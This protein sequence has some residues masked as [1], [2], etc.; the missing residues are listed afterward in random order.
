M[1]VRQQRALKSWVDRLK[2]KN[3]TLRE[4]VTA[5]KKENQILQK[6]LRES[7][8]LFKDIPGVLA[9]VQDGKIIL[10]NE[11][12]LKGLGNTEEEVLG[13]NFLE[14]IHP[15]S[16]EYGRNLHQKR[17]SGKSVPDQY[18][19]YLTTKNG[20]TL[21]C[22]VLVKGIR[23]QGR[24]AFLLYIRGLDQK[25]KSETQLL[26]SQKMEAIVRMASGL[27]REF[28]DCLSILDDYALHHNG[29]RVS[30]EV[31]PNESL[32][33]IEIIRKKCS[34]IREKLVT[35]EMVEYDETNT[36]NCDLRKIIRDAV[37][38][39]RY[40]WKEAAEER[41]IKV[42]VKTY[43]RDVSPVEGNPDELKNIF[44]NMIL[45]AIDALPGG[46]EV[47]LTTE[48]SAGYAYVYIQDNGVGIPDDIKDRIFDP[49]FTINDG[50]KV[51]L[52]LSIAYVAIKR[53]GGE[54]EVMSHKGKGGATFIIKLPIA[55]KHPS[56]KTGD[57]KKK[58]NNS[59][60]LV[61]TEGGMVK[62]ILSQLL[63]D[64][65]GIVTTA[66]ADIEWVKLL[67]KKKFDL[68]IADLNM[69]NL[70]TS[71]KISKIKKMHRDRPIIL[72]NAEEGE[73]F[74]EDLVI[75]RPLQMNRV[76]SLI[77]EVLSNKGVA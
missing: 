65:G 4:K 10:T 8:K 73:E 12:A 70:R 62:D 34:S 16:V 23:Y 18:E 6:A 68:V 44:V 49:F 48:E 75:G 30:S 27:S 9:L 33:G 74:G 1:G 56:P 43:L 40:L 54:V 59:R 50:S 60:I 13:R 15:D 2:D 63:V 51:G 29:E 36:V 45:N 64:K 32:K 61:I 37:G 14:F 47:Y 31:I 58:I 17:L 3:Q 53:H 25:K 42:D 55:Q 26:R 77:S 22:E 28:N 76:L 7:R 5:L 21:C 19:T 67:G 46:G 72:I 71:K 35:L 24:R 69:S 57:A 38:S 52:G 41:G 66:Y 11:A 20:E 39:T